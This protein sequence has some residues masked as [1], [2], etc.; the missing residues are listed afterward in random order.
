MAASMQ[1]MRTTLLW[2]ARNGWLR[3]HLPRLP[4]ARRAV[5]RFMPGEH[6]EDAVAAADRLD[7][8]GFGVLFTR[9]GENITD[10]AQADEVAEHYHDVLERSRARTEAA[11]SRPIEIS[12]KPTQLGL[13]ID[14]G[15]CVE[16]CE[17]LARHAQ[18]AGTWFWLDMEG[19]GYTEPT[20]A[21]YERLKREHPRVGIALQA[22]L[23]RTA[24]DVERLLPL[25]PCV[26]LVKGAYDEPAAVAYRKREEVDASYERLAGTLAV[27]AGQ[28]RARLALGTHDT[29]LVA[30]ISATAEAAGV[31][32]GATEVH[33]LY[34]IRQ[35]E[36][37]RLAADG[38]ACFSLVAYGEFWYA[39]YMR[40]LAER[41]ANVVF[42]LRQLLP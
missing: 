18:E 38:Y 25:E 32:R 4:F 1:P 3:D 10:R 16:H 34:G 6:V 40:R 8:Q 33:M 20:V 26:R 21:L 22:Y 30:R 2:M 37:V 19:S 27:A 31:P 41:P 35:D 9:L 36:L 42:A 14:E 11:G 39:W 17:A 7:G 15:L 13:D 28:G 23:R 5:R 29:E 12:V 24:S